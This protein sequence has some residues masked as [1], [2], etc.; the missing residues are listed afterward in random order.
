MRDAAGRRRRVARGRLDRVVAR[1]RDRGHRRRRRPTRRARCSTCSSTTTARSS[2]CSSGATRRAATTPS[3]SASTSS[4]TFPHARGRV[5]RRRPAA[6][7][8]PRRR[9]VAGPCRPVTRRCTLADLREI[10]ASSELKG[11]GDDARERA[12]RDGPAQRAR[13]A[14]ALPAPLRSTA[15]KQA[16]DRRA[17]GRRG[18]DGVRRG[19]HD[20]RRA[21]R[22]S[23]ARSSRRSCTTARS[24]LD[25]HV[26][27]PGVAR[28]AAARSAPRRRSSASSTC[29][30]GKRQMTNPVVDLRRRDRRP[31]RR[32]RARLPAVGE[33]RGLHVGARARSVDE[34]LAALPRGFA[35]PRRRGRAS[36]GSTSSTARPRSA[37][38]T[39][40]VDGRAGARRGGGSSSTSSCACRS[41]LVR[42]QARA[43]GRAR[44]ASAT[45]VDGDARATRS[46]DAAA[47]RAHRRP[48]ARDRRDRRR[49]R[50]AARRCTG[51]C[52]A[53]SARARPSS[54]VAALLV[55]VQGG[56]QGAFMA[57]TEVLAEQHYLGVAR[58]A[59]RASPC[60]PRAS[61][62]GRPAAARRAAHQPHDRR[63]S[64]GASLAGLAAGEVDILVGTHALI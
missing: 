55:A 15:R 1:R 20:P 62:L 39:A 34:A 21:A 4:D 2:P 24:L 27:Q 45:T 54:R 47:V 10:A 31:D 41:A 30:A 59:R 44:P 57:P 9:R 11:V 12:R 56:Y 18:G 40:R 48:A 3:A 25:D 23:G 28:E 7:P 42:A 6:V 35:D 58:A 16:D 60:R 43:R 14:A 51:C 61:L 17:R 8:V 29:T 53:T 46:I 50:R 32:D 22:G 63:P 36:T 13:P 19:A 5:P 52:R 49:P 26:L 38:S 37:A 33:G 64:A